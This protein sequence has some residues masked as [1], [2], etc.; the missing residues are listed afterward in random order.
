[1]DFRVERPG[2]A[3]QSS[4]PGNSSV[5]ELTDLKL[6]YV[7]ENRKTEVLRGLSFRIDLNATSSRGHKIAICGPSGSGKSTLLYILGGLLRPTSGRV[8]V[9]GE[10]IWNWDE[11]RRARFRA[12]SI[13]F[14]YQN[15]HLLPAWSVLDNVMLGAD[16]VAADQVPMLRERAIGLLN[17]LGLKGLESRTPSQLSGGQ[18]QRVAIARALLMNPQVILADEPTGALDPATAAE[19]MGIFDE[20][21]AEGRTVILIT[22]DEGVANSCEQI[23]RLRDGVLDRLDEIKSSSVDLD[24]KLGTVSTADREAAGHI[25]ASQMVAKDSAVRTNL[26]QHLNWRR[27]FGSSWKL[28][29]RNPSRNL[30][31]LFGV[32][33]GVAAVLSMITIG[34]FARERILESYDRLGVRSFRLWGY[35]N[36]NLPISKPLETY[37]REFKDEELA[38]LTRLFPDLEYYSP[39]A[40]F[41]GAQVSY[42][43]RS[44]T[45]DVNMAGVNEHG[46][47]L[48]EFSVLA[49][50]GISAIDVLE[51]N[52]VCVIGSGIARELE[53]THL[54]FKNHQ[55]E[56]PLLFVKTGR[57]NFACR[58]VGR[59]AEPKS[60]SSRRGRSGQE[61]I[62]PHSYVR[63]I[64]GESP[65]SNEGDFNNVIFEVRAGADPEKLSKHVEQ[66]FKQKY[67]AAGDFRASANNRV[68]EQMQRFLKIFNGLLIG[69]AFVTLLVG[70]TGV[71]NMILVSLGERLRELGLRRAVGAEPRDLRAMVI[72]ESMALCGLAGIVG[73]VSSMLLLHLVLYGVSLA[74]PDVKFVW[75]FDILAISM[76]LISILSVGIGSGLYPALRA[77]QLDVVA[78]LR[79]E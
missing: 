10:E 57:L 29:R 51:R 28:L 35:T 37:F 25:S 75:T 5:L 31:T 23:I 41:W 2:G 69:V 36:W 52:A 47:R 58:V 64:R 7:S 17:R 6:D 24:A 20:I 3:A 70:A 18:A 78:A 19:I 46:I 30:L 11:A 14:V 65:N 39:T 8:R 9:L 38:A 66:F 4:S 27:A 16:Y 59:L 56:K 1:M 32:A 42:G 53:L 76:S 45:E 34:R 33:I 44:V 72:G 61:L 68:L 43:G 73:L 62:L 74:F 21:C 49:G 67:G 48:N 55:S 63:A 22:H 60:A 26:F 71:T 54:D 50:R 15:F 40:N 77:E 13:G 12:A 79:A